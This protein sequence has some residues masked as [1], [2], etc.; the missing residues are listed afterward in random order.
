MRRFSLQVSL[1]VSLQAWEDTMA[2]EAA[3]RP[4]TATD[5]DTAEDDLH[6]KFREALERK[7]AE[8]HD[9]HGA[10]TQGKGVGPAFNDKR[11]RQFRRKSG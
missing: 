6:R 4:E 8:H 7:K 1:Q 2:D 10:A 3:S 11:Q 9:A 5:P